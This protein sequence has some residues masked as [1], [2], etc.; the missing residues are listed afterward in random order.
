MSIQRVNT[1]KINPTPRHKFS[2]IALGLAYFLLIF[3][4][5]SSLISEHELSGKKSHSQPN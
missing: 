1:I 3:I 4:C 2:F 5:L